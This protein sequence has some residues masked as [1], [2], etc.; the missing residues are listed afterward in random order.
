MMRAAAKSWNLGRFDAR[1][2]AE[3]GAAMEGEERLAA[4][5][6]L[7]DER[8]ADGEADPVVRWAVRGEMRS[9][10]AG[11]ASVW[12]HLQAW[13]DMPVACQRCLGAV[14]IPLEVDRWFRFVADEATAEAQDDESE[15][16]VLALE[17]RPDLLALIEDELLMAIPLVPMH[18][19]CPQPLSSQG[20][21]SSEGRDL[22]PEAVRPHPFAELSRLKKQG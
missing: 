21:S 15:E 14:T 10:S 11:Q 13:L 20:L 22:P 3:S 8:H 2:F 12:L 17:P 16:D 4:F 9:G 6:R 7:T 18:E 19:E 1:A 5:E